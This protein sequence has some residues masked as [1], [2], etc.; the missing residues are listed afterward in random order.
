[1][2]RRITS[3]SVSANLAL[4][5]FA[6]CQRS[7]C[8]TGA[9]GSTGP[10]GN[11]QWHE[12]HTQHGSAADQASKLVERLK[13]DDKLAKCVSK[14]LVDHPE[15]LAALNHADECAKAERAA[16]AKENG[17]K[18]SMARL[19]VTTALPFF[20]FGVC[21]NIIMITVGDVIDNHFGVIMGFSTMVAAGLG[22]AVSDGSG[23]TIQQ[24]LERWEHK[25]G[26]PEHGFT[27]EDL[28]GMHWKLQLFRT[29][30]I[31]CG[32]L[33]GLIPVIIYDAGN[34]PRLYDMLLEAL[35]EKKRRELSAR[36]TRIT[37]QPGDVLFKY[38]QEATALYA[39]TSGEVQV[40]GRDDRGRE[41]EY[42]TQGPGNSLG[43]L[44]LVFGHKCVADVK[45]I[46]KV[47]ALKISKKDFVAIAGGP[48]TKKIVRDYVKE[49]PAFL[50]YRLRFAKEFE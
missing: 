15:L 1:M 26:L 37:F 31:V 39:I 17:P 49:D 8:S 40:I 4:P 38:G 27:P 43:H 23:V 41:I 14:E 44:E 18:G 45:A 5:S 29:I 28:S 47:N 36:A 48:E 21:D 16:I 12:I 7:Y 35:P 9:G 3:R 2:L 33:A 22:Q 25:L 10:A 24:C 50:P 13:H 20:G 32:C 42:C 19:F 11:V 46:G 6:G 30:G 34:T